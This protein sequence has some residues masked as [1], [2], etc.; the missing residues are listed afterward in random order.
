MT[1]N[2]PIVAVPNSFESLPPHPPNSTKNCTIPSFLHWHCWQCC[3]QSRHR[4][5]HPCAAP[6]YS[7]TTNP[8]PHE[9][10]QYQKCVCECVINNNVCVHTLENRTHHLD[11]PEPRH[12]CPRVLVDRHVW[13]RVPAKWDGPQCPCGDV[14]H[15]N[16]STRQS[17]QPL[18]TRHCPRHSRIPDPC[19]RNHHQ[20]PFCC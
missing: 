8:A 14:P 18:P 11:R 1:S 3:W 15:D 5:S 17:G 6:M 20:H 12:D 2:Q 7:Q 10:L 9:E 4:Q 13:E 19:S 16:V